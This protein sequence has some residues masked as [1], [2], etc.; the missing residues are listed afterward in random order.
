MKVKNK[1]ADSIMNT[2]GIFCPKNWKEF[3]DYI[4][5]FVVNADPVVDSQN[6]EFV[7]VLKNAGK[8]E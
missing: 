4:S 6:Y 3:G 7:T 8:C 5:N 1:D 2:V